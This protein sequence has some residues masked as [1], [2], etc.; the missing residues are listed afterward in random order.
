MITRNLLLG[1]FV[2]LCF[3][4]LGAT[5][6]NAQT[7]CHLLDQNSA[8]PAG[9]ASPY[10]FQLNTL[11]ITVECSGT[12]ATITAGTGSQ[13]TYVYEN[14]Y[15]W[16]GVA[17]DPFT[18]TPSASK[19]GQWLIGQGSKT[20]TAPLNQQ[21]HIVAYTCHWT[22]S[23]WKCGCR[24]QT[25]TTPSWQIQA[26]SN[27]SGQP[28]SGGGGSGGNSSGGASGVPIVIY[29]TDLGPDI[30]D[31][32]ALAMLHAYEKRGLADIGAVTISRNGPGDWGPRYADAMNTYYG[33]PN[34][35]IGD[36][37]GTTGK[38]R[39]DRYS[40]VVTQSGKYPH[41]IHNSPIPEGYKVMR[42]VL[43]DAPDKSVVIVQTGFSGN[44][45]RLIR[46]GAD[47][48]SSKTGLQLIREKV[49][50]LSIMAGNRSINRPEFNIEND[51][52]SALIVFREW[53]V[54][55]I[56]SDW[57][58]GG[59]ILYP[60]SSIANDFAS[61][62]PI[63]ESYVVDTNIY[64]NWHPPTNVP[65]LGNTYN[66]RSWDLTSV[67]VGVEAPGKYFNL[68]GPG[69]VTLNNSGVDR[70]SASGGG[71]HR[72]IQHANQH[73]NGQRQAIINRMI[74]LV[75]ESP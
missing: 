9:F 32:L 15:T 19:A 58:V 68:S 11:G 1:F 70:F 60:A 24:D 2:P 56:Q 74:E 36:Y 21:T 53:P 71:Q 64:R 41:D 49:T 31:A 67:M 26:Y 10:N 8:L 22:G 30:D 65:G 43:A 47:E 57:N 62:H 38:D 52:Q 27:T 29:D 6:T 55:M 54:E 3:F 28:P 17:W 42:R 50:L 72:I 66:M 23:D 48:I 44:T 37:R 20:L 13:N 69:K 18:F 4:L 5:A 59:H 75:T 25:C 33:R 16:N 51:L 61:N 46:S 14:G 73:S 34:I 45:A 35:P 12:N 39:N 63:R 7:Q 40:R